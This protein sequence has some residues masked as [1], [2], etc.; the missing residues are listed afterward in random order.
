MRQ[1]RQEDTWRSGK[2]KRGGLRKVA[3]AV[4]SGQESSGYYRTP[5]G[6]RRTTQ[7][8][9][10]SRRWL[11]PSENPVCHRSGPARSGCGLW[12]NQWDP[13]AIVIAVIA[14]CQE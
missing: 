12:G 11:P 14:V 8:D 6:K 2:R 7:C 13:L 5:Q 10:G 4:E 9:R 1:P 3:K